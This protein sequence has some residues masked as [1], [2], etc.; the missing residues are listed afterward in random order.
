MRIDNLIDGLMNGSTVLDFV[1]IEVRNRKSFFSGPGRVEQNSRGFF[2]LVMY[3]SVSPDIDIYRVKDSN[4]L[5]GDVLPGTFLGDESFFSFSGAGLHSVEWIS[6][7]VWINAEVDYVNRIVILKGDIHVLESQIKTSGKKTYFTRSVSLHNNMFFP[8]NDFTK[9]E[10]SSSRN[11]SNFKVDDVSCHL[12]IKDETVELITKSDQP[13]HYNFHTGLRDALQFVTGSQLA[14]FLKYEIVGNYSSYVLESPR[15]EQHL[16]R[17]D[18]PIHIN[19]PPE[20]GRCEMLLA[21]LLKAILEESKPRFLSLYYQVSMSFSSG[22]AAAALASSVAVDGIA[23]RYFNSFYEADPAHHQECLKAIPLV[24]EIALSNPSILTTN[25]VSRIVG[26]LESSG[27]SSSK[28]TIYKIFGETLG[29]DW[30]AIRHAAAHGSLLDRSLSD[31]KLHDCIYSCIF[32]YYAMVLAAIDY[33]H[34]II[35]IAKKDDSMIKNPA[36]LARNA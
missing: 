1:K 20:L 23:D 36:R 11:K 19:A 26:S 5:S 9:N 34:E 30:N 15:K 33:P 14:T 24:R 6:E 31:Q 4:F 12:V 13:L 2:D 27:R 22:I 3:P 32:M 18:A 28:N 10:N 16:W 25:V 21:C 29:D 35:N 7:N 17:M 8:C